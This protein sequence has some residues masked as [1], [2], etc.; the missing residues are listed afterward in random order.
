MEER[1]T[2][3]TMVTSKE[4]SII[5]VGGGAFGLSTAL[6]LLT[7][8]YRNVTIF[9]CQDFETTKY[10][11]FLGA[12][13]ASS[14]T[15]KVI[16]SAYGSESSHTILATEAISEWKEWNNEAGRPLFVNCGWTRMTESGTIAPAEVA[17]QDNLQKSGKGDTQYRITN[18]SDRKRANSDGWLRTKYDPFNRL[19]RGLPVDG[20]LD[21]LAGFVYADAACVFALNKVKQLGGKVILDRQSGRFESLVYAS[22]N[23]QYSNRKR[24]VGIRTSDGREHLSEVV[25]M[26][27][28]SQTHGLVPG[29]EKIA[30]TSGANIVHVKVPPSVRENFRSNVFPVFSWN[31]TGYDEDGGLSGFPIDEHGTLKFLHRSPKW[32]NPTPQTFEAESSLLTSK[33]IPWDSD[34]R[35]NVPKSVVETV[36]VFISANIPELVGSDIIIA[37]ICWDSFG[38]DLDFVMDWVPGIENCMVVAGGSGHGFKFLPTLGKYVVSVLEG[39]KNEFTDKWKWRNPSPKETEKFQ[40]GIIDPNRRLDQQIMALSSDLLWD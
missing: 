17:T 7:N 22:E 32:T 8:G 37:K 20:V 14:D 5:I 3:L 4:K 33:F 2:I 10:S 26:A 9:D 29:L 21:T 34:T 40:D 19:G 36:K 18:D 1:P 30:N 38:I 39:R 28:G 27:T 31:Y 11:P 16:R 12:D 23:L 25:I 13:S 35:T 15:M 24:A 6:H